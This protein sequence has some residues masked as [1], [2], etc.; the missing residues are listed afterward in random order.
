MVFASLF[1]ACLAAAPSC[2]TVTPLHSAAF[3]PS[4]SPLVTDVDTIF[5]LGVKSIL[6]E[7]PDGFLTTE[8]TT[9]AAAISACDSLRHCWAIADGTPSGSYTVLLGTRC[10]DLLTHA[11]QT[12]CYA[13]VGP[14]HERS[15]CPPRQ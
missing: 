14:P 5:T 8:Y 12:A 4:T 15:V 3:L 11:E 7:T 13:A 2:E 10:M 6:D 1:S 9:K